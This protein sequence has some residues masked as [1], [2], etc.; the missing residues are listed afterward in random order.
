MAPSI[1]AAFS[2]SHGISLKKDDRMKMAIGSA[3]VMYGR[4]RPGHVSNRPSLR[5]MSNSGL[6]SDT[7]GNIAMSSETPRITDLPGNVRRAMA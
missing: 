2:S 4:I 3:N 7:C 1:C 6:T 5:S